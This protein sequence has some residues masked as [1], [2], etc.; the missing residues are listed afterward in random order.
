MDKL[1]ALIKSQLEQHEFAVQETSFE[2]ITQSGEISYL[3]S[4]PKL[5]ECDASK[6]LLMFPDLF[7][8]SK[9][10]AITPDNGIFFVAV[11]KPGE[12]L[13]KEACDI[14]QKYFPP[15]IAVISQTPSGSLLASWLQ[16]ID[17]PQPLDT[18][19]QVEVG[20]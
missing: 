2:A 1:I 14:Y 4:I 12:S 15:K 19:L 7:V 6:L 5:P 3:R 10:R 18:F 11:V 13:S 17:A 8:V 20:V 16:S 9:N